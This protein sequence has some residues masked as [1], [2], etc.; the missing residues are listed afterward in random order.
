M[1]KFYLKVRKVLSKSFVNKNKRDMK[2]NDIEIFSYNEKNFNLS[3]E[4]ERENSNFD[5]LLKE[6]WTQIEKNNV[7]RYSVKSQRSKILDGKYKF[8]AQV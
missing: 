1:K 2:E 3:I 6:K 5:S 4:N 8:Y 7:L